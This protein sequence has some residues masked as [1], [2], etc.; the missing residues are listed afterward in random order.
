MCIISSCIVTGGS[1]R[2]INPFGRPS[3]MDCISIKDYELNP[4][5]ISYGWAVNNTILFENKEECDENNLLNICENIKKNGKLGIG[6]LDNL[7][8]IREC[9]MNQIIKI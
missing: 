6:Y 7:E 5:R 8:F 1:R 3:D 9:V 2:C 4:E